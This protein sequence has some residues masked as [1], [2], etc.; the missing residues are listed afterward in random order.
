MTIKEKFALRSL[1][2]NVERGIWTEDKA[3]EEFTK[4]TGRDPDQVPSEDDEEGQE[5]G[6]FLVALSAASQQVELA[7]LEAAEQDPE[8]LRTVELNPP[9]DKLLANRGIV[10]P[11]QK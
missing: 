10:V 6:K 3:R 4:I 7:Q 11:D 2:Q 8:D 5:L 1:A 9:T